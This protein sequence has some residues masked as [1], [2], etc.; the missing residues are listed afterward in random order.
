MPSKAI[1]LFPQHIKPSPSPSPGKQTQRPAALTPSKS[2]QKLQNNEPVSPT[3]TNRSNNIPQ[4]PRM[5]K[6]KSVSKLDKQSGSNKLLLSYDQTIL[7]MEEFIAAKHA[8]NDKIK[9]KK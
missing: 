2:A 3:F 6:S 4:S 1:D 5:G 8:H 7:L 9:K